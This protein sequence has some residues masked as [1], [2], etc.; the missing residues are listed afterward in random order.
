MSCQIKLF[1]KND[2]LLIDSE[3]SYTILRAK[4]L[5]EFNGDYMP[6][7]FKL[8]FIDSSGDVNQIED[9]RDMDA[10][11]H[12]IMPKKRRGSGFSDSEDEDKG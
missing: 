6:R 9:Q 8:F 5:K 4:I 2:A 1:Y 12:L 10:I 3:T 7:D 11:R